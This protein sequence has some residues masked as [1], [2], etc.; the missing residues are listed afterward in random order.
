MSKGWCEVQARIF[1]TCFAVKR[2]VLSRNK[3]FN[4]VELNRDLEGLGVL[5]Y[6]INFSLQMM[7]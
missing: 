6:L 2:F 5:A 4:K 1:T 3:Y 7:H